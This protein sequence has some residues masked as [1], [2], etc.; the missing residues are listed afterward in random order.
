[1]S[2]VLF[3]DLHGNI[4][5]STIE[6]ALPLHGGRDALVSVLSPR[7]AEQSLRDL[8]EARRL[9]IGGPRVES[10]C[11]PFM[12]TYRTI[13]EAGWLAP[14]KTMD[15]LD[16]KEHVCSSATIADPDRASSE[17]SCQGSRT[18]ARH[19][20]WRAD[21]SCRVWTS[22]KDSVRRVC[23]KGRMG[24]RD[25]RPVIAA[26]GERGKRSSLWLYWS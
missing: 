24:L 15:E 21:S 26:V 22:F 9:L 20:T 25:T 3:V 18:F 4:S 14:A 8:S 6:H 7:G 16:G 5:I 13:V 23:G 1:M 2:S 12:A 10:V 11:S 17:G 19:Y